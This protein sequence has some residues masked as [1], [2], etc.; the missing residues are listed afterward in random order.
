MTA[1]FDRIK[2][3]EK[4][5]ISKREIAKFLGIA[6][7]LI[8][9]VKKWLYVIF[10]HRADKGGQFVSYRKIERWRNAVACQIQN[11]VNLEELQQLGNAIRRDCQK[12]KKQY[13][14]VVLRFLDRVWQQRREFVVQK[15]AKEEGLASL[16][17]NAKELIIYFT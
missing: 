4:F 10:V 16:V 11:C 3:A 6:E 7:S 12:Y 15:L 1:L 9:E 13:E 8:K 17:T 5:R 2:P 14:D